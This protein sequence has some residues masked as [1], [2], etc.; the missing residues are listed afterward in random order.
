MLKTSISKAC[1]YNIISTLAVILKVNKIQILGRHYLYRFFFVTVLF[2]LAGCTTEKN[3]VVSRAYHNLSAHYNVY[4]NGKES[5]RAGVEKINNSVGDDYSKILPVFK[6]SNPS[7]ATAAN[8]EME[9]AILKGSKLIQSH[10]ITKK[11]KR[12]KKRSKSY[13]RFASREEFNNWVDDAYILMGKAY[14][15]KKNYASAIE[16]FSY[17]VRK[18]ENDPSRYVAYIW[19]IRSYAELQRYVEAYE[20]IQ[21]IQLDEKFPRQLEGELAAATSDYYARQLSYTEGIPFLSIAAEHAGKKEDRLRYK[22]ILAQWYQETGNSEKASQIFRE[23]ARMNPPY[24]MAFNAHISAAGTFTGLGDVDKLKKEL[25]KML[26]DKKNLEFRDQIYF[27]MGNISMK[28]GNKKKAI[29]EYAMSASMSID[30]LYQRALSC[31]TLAQIYFVEPEYKKAQSYYDSAMVVIDDKYPDY[32]QISER[33]KS[34]TRLTDNIYTVERED[35]LQRIALMDE[36]SR[37]SLI[38]KWIKDANDKEARDRLAETSQMMDQNYFRSNESRFGL[39][40]KQ[41]S[42]GWYFYSPTTVA[43]GKVEFERLWGKRKL[44][45][46]WRRS[47]KRAFSGGDENQ[48]EDSLLTAKGQIKKIQ[49]PKSR[50]FYTQDLPVTDSLMTVSH[51]KIRNALFS[52]GRIFKTDFSDFPRAIESFEDLNKRY[53]E[54]MFTLSSWFELWDLYNKENNQERADYYKSLITSQYPDSKYAKYLLN[55]NYFIEL[56]ART[57]SVNRLYQQAYLEFKNG[58]YAQAGTMADEMLLMQPDSTLIPKIEFIR[59]IAEGTASARES[60]GKLLS[61]YI[62]DYPKAEPKPLAEQILKLIQDSTLVDYQKMVAS[63]YLNDQIQNKELLSGDKK[64][65]DE[66]EGKFS[67]DEDLLHYFVI[68]YPKDASLDLNRLKFD[69]ANYNIDHYTK[70]D[71]DIETQ[72]LNNNT[73][74]LIVRSLND[75]E[76]GLIYFRSIIKRRIVFEALKN[77]KY[78]NFIAS[79]TNFREIMSDKDYS[80]YLKFFVLNYSRFISG[81]FSEEILPEPEELLAKAQQEYALKEKGSFVTVSPTGSGLDIYSGEESGL[82]NFVIAVNDPKV[83][84]KQIIAGFNSYNRDEFR[85]ANL[86]IRQSQVDDYKLIIV[87]TFKSK[88]EA[89]GYFT[90]TL[91]NRKLFRSLDTLGYRNFIITD[92]NLK[93]LT[94]TKRMAEYL[95]FFKTKYIDSGGGAN[96]QPQEKDTYN[97]PY[98]LNVNSMQS[99]ILIISKE[100]MNPD[101]LVQAIRQFNQQ[102]YPQQPLAVS[103][104]MLDDFRLL[105]KVEGL[106]NIQSGLDYLRALAKDQQV[107]GPIQNASYRNFIITPENELIFRQSKN[108]LTYMEFYKLFYLKR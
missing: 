19:L 55:P 67:Y 4:F 6:S 81:D 83:N 96:N 52:A 14:F 63:G 9:N 104:G 91:A 101:Q 65:S 56:E 13:I 58:Q 1:V 97:G 5:L 78:V 85:Q 103:S 84:L 100:E 3:T 106:S 105:V 79:S 70:V 90:K 38:D 20:I 54:N 69:L 17:V 33:H 10:S 99:F 51:A 21:K 40:Q 74:L 88:I 27:A 26:R 47:D 72:S 82:Q 86:T 43:Y 71:F 23:V 32:Q 66:F 64:D 24:K 31:L 49:D 95:N 12:R 46:A 57:D 107:Y 89:I 30:N 50:D 28:E 37:N 102:N 77:I 44:E 92:A 53:P 8:A 34:L 45:D 93:K 61:E 73:S 7:T 75:K 41:E 18:F 29:E 36:S 87:S 94:E 59:I 80:E 68:G 60:F 16:N 35:S 108:V 76:Q 2:F 11:P 22:Y 98:N 42:A 39:S 25:R 62:A 48:E 15:Y